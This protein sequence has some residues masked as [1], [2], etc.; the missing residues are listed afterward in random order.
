M[1][2]HTKGFSNVPLHSAYNQTLQYVTKNPSQIPNFNTEIFRTRGIIVIH[3]SAL[4]R[5]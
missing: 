3:N 4:V 1:S 5:Y 2:I